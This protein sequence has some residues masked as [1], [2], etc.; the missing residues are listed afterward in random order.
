LIV[1]LLQSLHAR[2]ELPDPNVF[3]ISQ[4]LDYHLIALYRIEPAAAT[5]H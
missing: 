5:S 3:R 4:M 2:V 1:P